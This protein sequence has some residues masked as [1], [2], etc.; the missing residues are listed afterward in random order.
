MDEPLQLLFPL[1]D[2]REHTC[3]KVEQLVERV[4]SRCLIRC[5]VF[6][7]ALEP[8]RLNIS[9]WLKLNYERRLVLPSPH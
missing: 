8:S 5:N 4:K 1:A 2:F 6:N 7:P 9:L 3:E